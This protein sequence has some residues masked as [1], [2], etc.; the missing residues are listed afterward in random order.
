LPLIAALGYFFGIRIMFGLGLLAILALFTVAIYLLSKLFCTFKSKVAFYTVVLGSIVAYPFAYKLSPSYANFLNLCSNSARYNVLKTKQV[1][2]IYLDRDVGS[3]CKGGPK[4]IEGLPF[5][6]FDCVAPNTRTTT[7]IFRYTKTAEWYPGCGVECFD[8]KVQ[9]D[10]E[11]KYKHGHRQGYIEGLTIKI[12][13]DQ[14][15]ASAL[16]QESSGDKLKFWDTLLLDAGV[17][18]A[19]KRTY[20]YLPY[21][22]GWAKILGG[23]SGSAPSQYCEDKFVDWDIRDVYKPLMEKPNK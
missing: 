8:S 15:G 23:A 18:M 11:A 12:T 9:S 22:S 13:Y 7:A 20:V 5:A 4:F 10:P 2:Y 14:S 16:A 17:E 19:H 6:G 1:D 3:D 21:G